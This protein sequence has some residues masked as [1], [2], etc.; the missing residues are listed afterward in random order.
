[1]TPTLSSSALYSNMEEEDKKP[2]LEGEAEDAVPLQYPGR[3]PRARTWSR[4]A[5]WKP[6]I[7]LLSIGCLAVLLLVIGAF[8]GGIFVGK[9]IVHNETGGSRSCAKC[10][11]SLPS[12]GNGSTHD[13]TY[14]WGA[15]VSIGGES[16]RVVDWLDTNMTAENMKKNLM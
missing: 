5:A 8:V 6:R 3:T 13:M 14:N 12:S 15:N 7:A 1:M 10:N 11:H 9:Q 4:K 16:V 2:F